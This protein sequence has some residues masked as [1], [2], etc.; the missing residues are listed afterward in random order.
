MRVAKLTYNTCLLIAMN[1]HISKKKDNIV[2]DHEALKPVY[3]GDKPDFSLIYH[4]IVYHKDPFMIQKTKYTSVLIE[5]TITKISPYWDLSK[6]L[7]PAI[8]TVSYVK[9]H[10]HG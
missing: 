8:K 6:H 3:Y 2:I 10:A 9:E 1:N 7:N 5:C 4:S